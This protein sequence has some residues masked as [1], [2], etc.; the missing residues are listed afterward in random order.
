MGAFDIIGNIAILSA[1]SLSKK[2]AKKIAKKIL[3]ENKHIHSVFLKSKI[4]GRLRVPKLKWLAG[5]RNTK[6]IHRESGCVFKLNV[7]TCYFSPRL[8][9]DRLDIAKKVKK[10]ERVLVMFSGVAPYPIVIARHSKAKQ[11]YGVELSK[12][13]SRYA[14]ENV[15][16][17][18]IDNIIL[19]QGDVKKIIPRLNQKFDRVVMARPQ[20]KE[21]FL[22]QAF[23]ISK[24]GTVIHFYDFV[25]SIDE[26]VNKVKNEANRMK[27]QVKLIDVKKVREIAPYKYHVRIDFIIK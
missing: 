1:S 22:R 11:I 26:A 2:E 9:T 21:T 5:S 23:L 10:G 16:L 12:E 20:L 19:I 4:S 15:K 13:A 24:R 6:T 25:K 17:N 18:K 8:G 7:K 27:K 3:R 14:E